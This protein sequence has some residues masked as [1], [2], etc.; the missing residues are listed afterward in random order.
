MYRQIVE[1]IRS[2][3]SPLLLTG[4]GGDRIG[5]IALI[6]GDRRFGDEALLRF[7]GQIDGKLPRVEQ[8]ILVERISAPPELILLGGGHVSVQTAKVAKLCGFRVTVVDDRPEFANAARFPEA[9][10]IWNRPFADAIDA[11]D[12][13]SAWYV[14]V[15][16]GHRDDRA[17]LERILRRPFAYCGMIGSRTK[18]G[19][20]F[21]H[22]LQ[23]GF[24]Q[25]Q[26]ARVH[27]PIGLSIGAVTPEEI[28]VSIVG[29]LISVRNGG[30]AVVAWDEALCAGILSADVPYAMVTLISKTG[31][32]PRGT[33][34]RMLVCGDGTILSSI[35]GGY[36]E[37]EAAQYA[38]SML[39]SGPDAKRY[40]CSMTNEDAAKAGMVCGGTVEVL[41]QIVREDS[42]WKTSS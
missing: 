34:A 41:I 30:G 38:L 8:D 40:V 20:V 37:Y 25:E 6:D 4:V 35:G 24:S 26:L 14:I 18:V 21:E 32:A 15:T 5:K 10:R 17:C 16:R 19:L 1:A 27:A 31:S 23:N 9:D 36:G 2:G 22:L 3:R 12:A 7:A 11:I 42:E 28:A 39:Q 29:E 13:Q 33:G